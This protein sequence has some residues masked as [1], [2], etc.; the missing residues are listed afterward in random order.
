MERFKK[1]LIVFAIILV[2]I[3][4][5]AQ[6]LKNYTLGDKINNVNITSQTRIVGI[7]GTIY[8]SALADG[9]VYKI[10]FVPGNK[11]KPK[12][13][14][15]RE[16]MRFKNYIEDTYDIKLNEISHEEASDTNFSYHLMADYDSEEHFPYIIH[17]SISNPKL[18]EE[19]KSDIA[20]IE[21]HSLQ[22]NSKEIISK[23]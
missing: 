2:S 11:T 21:K 22:N 1:V 15:Y 19:L 4:V 7:V 12:R 9:R 23:Q 5:N 18:M 10:E 8:P 13:S 17:F 14:S 20:L 3:S 6:S 16:V